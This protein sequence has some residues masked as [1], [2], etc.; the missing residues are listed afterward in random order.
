M[1]PIELCIANLRGDFPKT[2][3]GYQ[4]KEEAL[5]ELKRRTGQYFG[6]DY[7]VWEAWLRENPE[8]IEIA[9]KTPDEVR[10][11]LRSLKDRTS[12]KVTKGD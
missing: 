3:I 1:T 11:L 4:P 12:T 5:A 8:V 2:A 9:A 10:R 7:R 6:E